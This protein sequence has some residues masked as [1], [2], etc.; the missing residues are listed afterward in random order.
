MLKD[1]FVVK[2][3]VDGNFSGCGCEKVLGERVF[4]ARIDVHWPEVVSVHF[5]ESK[6]DLHPDAQLLWF[7]DPGFVEF[8]AGDGS[9]H[10]HGAGG[11]IVCEYLWGEWSGLADHRKIAGGHFLALERD[12]ENFV[13]GCVDV[14][15]ESAREFLGGFEVP[16]FGQFCCDVIHGEV[17][18]KYGRE[19]RSEPPSHPWELRS[20]W[21]LRVSLPKSKGKGLLQQWSFFDVGPTARIER[22]GLSVL[23]KDWEESNDIGAGNELFA[24]LD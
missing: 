19:P 24:G 10:E 5:S 22:G 7:I 15:A 14:G 1:I 18:L 13:G 2:V 20:S 9:F 6:G 3:A 8:G 11:G 17:L 12:F 4:S 21:T 23:F 16:K